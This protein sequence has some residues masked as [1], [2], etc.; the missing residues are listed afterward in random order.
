MCGDI[1]NKEEASLII[2]ED[3]NA[4]VRETKEHGVISTF[5]LSKKN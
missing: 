2:L 5:G 1:N 4:V 3:W